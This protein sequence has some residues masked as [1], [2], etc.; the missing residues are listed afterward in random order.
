MPATNEQDCRKADQMTPQIETY[1]IVEGLGSGQILGV[2]ECSQG[3]LTID[4]TKDL[5]CFDIETNERYFFE[6]NSYRVVKS[7]LTPVQADKEL[8]FSKNEPFFSFED[9]EEWGE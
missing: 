8:G 9:D 4:P 1:A 2:E 3:G 6:A 5:E 7:G